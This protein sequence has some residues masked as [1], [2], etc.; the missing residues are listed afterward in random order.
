V[1][2]GQHLDQNPKS[3]MRQIQ[4]ALIYATV[5]GIRRHGPDAVG[6]LIF[7]LIGVAVTG[8]SAFALGAPPWVVGLGG[9]GGSCLAAA[10]A[11]RKRRLS[12]P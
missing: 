8:L 6:V 4:D 3:A 2:T 7:A 12:H 11:R 10:T 1:N 5:T 9:G